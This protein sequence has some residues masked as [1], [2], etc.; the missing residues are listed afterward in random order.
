MTSKNDQKDQIFLATTALEEFW[1]TSKPI[2][3]LGEWCLLYSRRAYWEKLNGRLLSSP[4]ATDDEGENA[5]QDISRI[6]EK[7][8][9]LLGDKLN[10]IHGKAYGLRYW[11][12]LIGPW[13]Q[14]YLSTI[15]D[16]YL[17][18]KHAL[19]QH[20]D[21]ATIG[22]SEDSFVVPVDTLDIAELMKGDAYNLQLYTRIMSFLG[23]DSPCKDTNL[24]YGNQYEKSPN[25]SWMRRTISYLANAIANFGA[26]SQKTTFLQASYF[27]KQVWLQLIVRNSGRILPR[28]SQM[29]RC[30][31]MESNSDKRSVLRAIEIGENE[32]ERCLSAMLFSDVPQCFVEGF[33]VIENEVKET[34]PTHPKAIFT[35]NGWYFDEYFKQWAAM[36]AE[37]GSFLLGTQHGGGYGVRKNK[38]AEDHET[39]V[40]DY[41]Y[42]WGW[43]RDECTATVIPMPA[44]N[45]TGMKEM[46][47]DSG[48]KGI[49][50]VATAEP[51]YV[52]ELPR[53]PMHLP[54]YFKRQ[55]RFIQALPQEMMR[56]LRFRPHKEDHGWGILGRIRECRPDIQIESW[57]I[58]FLASL[59][60]CRLYVCDHLSTTYAQSLAVN[61]PTILFIYNQQTTRLNLQA[62]PY[63]NLLREVG[64]LFDT[65]EAAASAVSSVY[66]DVE[67]WWNA[68]ERQEAIKR[69]CDHYAR[70][71]PNAIKQW[72]D[73]FARISELQSCDRYQ[74]EQNMSQH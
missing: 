15:Y 71:S 2:V 30:P 17:H 39:A 29:K 53:L 50:W 3:F 25:D 60:N 46:G 44:T 6:Y 57:E 10:T 14:I 12:I 7:T 23:K 4:Y 64:I 66:D 28:S 55:T 63:F 1:E 20:P 68:P 58:P 45:F 11:R 49:L 47:A 40:V 54:E 74:A 31:R 33:Q 21:F 5:Y 18:I 35:S 32:F 51:R 56:V 8:L 26:I 41:Y 70:T 48:K 52:I 38:R 19:D 16:H 37:K 22:L 61:K 65:P 42:S 43:E 24:L 67:T 62:K 69:F 36:S 34:Y 13:L 59:E 9:P 73:E 27:R 72:S